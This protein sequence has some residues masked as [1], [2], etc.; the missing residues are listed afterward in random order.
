MVRQAVL[1]QPMEVNGGADIHLQPVEDPTLEQVDA[2]KGGC[3]PHGKLALEQAPGR[4]CGPMER[5]AHA[6]AGL[7]AGLVTP[8]GTQ[9]WSSLFLKDCTLWKG[10][11][12]EQFLKTCSPWEGLMLEKFMEDC[13]L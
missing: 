6:G 10:P 11:T 4:T 3:D 13:L 7:L 1:L 8:W 9:H 2:P 12:L 5:G